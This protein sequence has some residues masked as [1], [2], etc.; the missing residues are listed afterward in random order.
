MVPYCY[1]FFLI[2]KKGVYS[3]SYLMQK[4]KQKADQR[5][6]KKKQTDKKI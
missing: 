1:L 2:S 6:Q 3:K 4:K 5:L